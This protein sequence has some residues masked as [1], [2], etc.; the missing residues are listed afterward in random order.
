MPPLLVLLVLAQTP[1]P[2]L[3]AGSGGNATA[4]GIPDDRAAALPALESLS[5]RGGPGAFDT[6]ADAAG[7]W[8]G[9]PELEAHARA[10]LARMP[11]DAKTLAAALSDP[12][13]NRRAMA[14]FAGGGGQGD[15]T[16]PP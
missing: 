10:A 12:D 2:A 13:P 6:I 16:P 11:V 4:A 7:R 14:A 15:R 5:L 8:K 3:V 9:D 1:V